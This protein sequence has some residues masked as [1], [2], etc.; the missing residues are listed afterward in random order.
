MFETLPV[1]PM[2]IFNVMAGAYLGFM[3]MSGGSTASDKRKTDEKNKRKE[4]EK[5]D[6]KRAEQERSVRENDVSRQHLARDA[7]SLRPHQKQ[8]QQN[9]KTMQQQSK[10]T[11][12]PNL[13]NAKYSSVDDITGPMAG[14]TINSYVSKIKQNIANYKGE[15]GLGAGTSSQHV[16]ELIEWFYNELEA[17]KKDPA[18]SL[19]SVKRLTELFYGEWAKIPDAMGPE[20]NAPFT[21]P[22]TGT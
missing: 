21:A 8:Q 4:K 18:V 7:A 14:P 3:L 9:P 6:K 19:N 1:A 11:T 22:P 5:E 10:S 16:R 2:S 12:K 13:S 15:D 17:K 20:L